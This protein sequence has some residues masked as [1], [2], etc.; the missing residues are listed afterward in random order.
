[1]NQIR[2]Y[3]DEDSFNKSLIAAFR[4][5]DIDVIT[6][7]DVSKQS[8]SDEDQLTWAS[9]NERAIY[10]YNRRDFCRLHGEFLSTKHNHA[11]IIVL[12]Q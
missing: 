8:C 12:R 9:E 5:A 2:L 7:A 10:S 4:S 11:G 6:V 1:M 3:I